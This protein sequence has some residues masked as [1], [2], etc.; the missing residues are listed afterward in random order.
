MESPTLVQMTEA[1]LRKVFAKVKTQNLTQ[2][3]FEGDKTERISALCAAFSS[4]PDNSNHRDELLR[5][6]KTQCGSHF[7]TFDPLSI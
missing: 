5:L 3:Q 1:H 6:L 2:S 4:L 7:Q